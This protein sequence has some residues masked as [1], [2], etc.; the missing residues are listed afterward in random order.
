[1]ALYVRRKHANQAEIDHIKDEKRKLYGEKE[2]LNE[3]FEN[4]RLERSGNLEQI[5]DLRTKILQ[6]EKKLANLHKL[7]SEVE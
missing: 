1:M 2:A 6:T 7:R 3:D 5:T 4:K